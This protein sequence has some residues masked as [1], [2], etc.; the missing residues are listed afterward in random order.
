MLCR[1]EDTKGLVVKN[2][3]HDDSLPRAGDIISVGAVDYE[4]KYVRHGFAYEGQKETPLKSIVVAAAKSPPGT[5]A[6]H[7]KKALNE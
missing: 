6:A 2:N 1:I 5:R 4:V 7:G 3:F